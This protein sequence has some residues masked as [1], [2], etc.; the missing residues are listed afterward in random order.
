M[1]NIKILSH[2]CTH[3]YQW[4]VNLKIGVRNL[5][6]TMIDCIS[7]SPLLVPAKGLGL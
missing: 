4:N 7:N 2:R 1:S 5:S 3:V 6:T